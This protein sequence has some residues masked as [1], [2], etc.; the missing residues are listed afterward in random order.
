[1][2]WGCVIMKVALGVACGGDSA[3]VADVSSVVPI[4]WV[5]GGVYGVA[6]GCIA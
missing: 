4:G 5:A 2:A 6:V 3:G 1:M